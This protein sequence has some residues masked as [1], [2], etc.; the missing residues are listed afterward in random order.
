VR[1]G[2]VRF[3]V[4]QPATAKLGS[5]TLAMSPLAVGGAL[6]SR[7]QLHHRTMSLTSARLRVAVHRL[8]LLH[9]HRKSPLAKP[10]SNSSNQVRTAGGT[11]STA[12]SGETPSHGAPST[13]FKMLARPTPASSIS[14]SE[15]R[16]GRFSTVPP[17]VWKFVEP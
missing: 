13:S 16:S 4:P 15:I 10:P 8:M 14:K 11:Q 9:R 12:I 17:I 5:P 2:R 6:V 3:A 1:L 7:A